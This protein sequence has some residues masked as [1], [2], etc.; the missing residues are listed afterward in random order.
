MRE[1]VLNLVALALFSCLMRLFCRCV[2]LGRFSQ[3]DVVLC[4]GM[5]LCGSSIRHPC[6]VIEHGESCGCNNF[7]LENYGAWGVPIGVVVSVVV[8]WQSVWEV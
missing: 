1:D 7:R 5:G 8:E 4:A 2:S 3:R 6:S